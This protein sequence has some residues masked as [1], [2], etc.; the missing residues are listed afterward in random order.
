MVQKSCAPCVCEVNA[1]N[2]GLFVEA[3]LGLMAGFA[4]VNRKSPDANALD[5]KPFLNALTL[6]VPFVAK[7]KGTVYSTPLVGVGSVPLIVQ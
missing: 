2:T 3:P 5:T 6:R 7:T 1:T 4:T